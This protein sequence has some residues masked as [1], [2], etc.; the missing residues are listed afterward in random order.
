M[1]EQTNA[2]IAVIGMGCRFPGGANDPQS[3]WD[4]ME[5][6]IDAIV[7]APIDRWDIGKYTEK[8]PDLP[9]RWGG[10]LEDVGWFDADFFHISPREAESM[11]P[12]QRLILEVAWEAIED[13]G[14]SRH[15]NPFG[16]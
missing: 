7:E 3:F 6:G 15:R 5:N 10:F 4:L 2:P 13:A 12:Q 16:R 11:D 9:L 8:Q 1:T 14:M